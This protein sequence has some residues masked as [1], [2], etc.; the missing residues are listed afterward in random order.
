MAYKFFKIGAANARI[1][2]LEKEVAELKAQ[3]KAEADAIPESIT[4]LQAE[5][6]KLVSD[7]ATAKTSLA[8]AQKSVTAITGERDTAVAKVAELEKKVAELPKL[9]AQQTAEIQAQIGAP[10]APVVP[11]AATAPKPVSGM[12][13]VRE[14]AMKDLLAGGFVPRK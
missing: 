9:A 11:A 5:N 13:A 2:E 1:D 10:A 14:A 3:S 8:D 7:L 4:A 12:T 6:Q